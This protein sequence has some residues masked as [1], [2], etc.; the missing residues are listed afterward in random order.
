M[1]TNDFPQYIK[2]TSLWKRTLGQEDPKVEPLR[3]SFL[4]ARKNIVFLLE[5]IHNDFPDLTMHDITHVDSLWRVADTIIGPKYPINPL[6]GY[7]LGIAF[8]IHDAA[9]SYDAI[10]GVDK[11]RET[12]EWKDYHAIKPEGVDDKEFEKQCDF[13]T[14]RAL[15]AKNAEKIL[16]KEFVDSTGGKI[17]IIGHESYRKHLKRIIGKI[18]ASHHWEIGDVKKLR[19]QAT[20]PDDINYQNDWEYNEQKL[21][22]ILRC[23]DAGHFDSG[24][25]PD[26]FYFNRSL[27]INDV[28]RKYWAAQNR[29][30]IVRE[31]KEDKTKLLISSDNPFPKDSFDAW[32]VAYEAVVQFDE[33]LK[34]S[35]ELLRLL[36][37]EGKKGLEFPHNGVVGAESKRLLS[38]YIK[39]EGWEPCSFGV[40]TSNVKGL[41]EKLG[42]SQLYGNNNRLLV[43]LRELIQNARDAMYAR[44]NLDDRYKIDDN[45][46]IIRIQEV[47]DKIWFEVE[48]NGIG[49]SLNCIKHHLL[50][51]GN[52]YW[53]SS[54]C[55][56][57]N[58]GL[59]SS[60]FFSVGEHGIGFYS[61]FMVAKSV[62]V[63]TRRHCDGKEAWKVEFPKGLTMSPILSKTILNT[64]VSTIVRFELRNNEDV[65]IKCPYLQRKTHYYE[66]YRSLLKALSIATIGL[67]ASVQ[68]EVDDK[69]SMIHTNVLSPTFNKHDWLS[70]L[71]MDSPKNLMDLASKFEELIDETGKLRGMIVPPEWVDKLEYSWHDYGGEI[72]FAETIGGL[73]ANTDLNSVFDKEPHFI[74]GYL[75]GKTGN[76]SRNKVILDNSLINCLRIWA[77]K[78]YRMFYNTKIASNKY[79]LETRQIIEKYSK[80]ISFCQLSDSI[81]HEN[82]KYLYS[83]Y[84]E[85]PEIYNKP[86]GALSSLSVIH[87]EL[88]WGVFHDSGLMCDYEESELR[89][90][91]KVIE[92]DNNSATSIEKIIE[93][94]V[95]NSRLRNLFKICFRPE[96]N[97]EQ[98]IEK[99]TLMLSL[100]PFRDG[101]KR[102]LSIWL[103]FLLY[104]NLHKMID[105]K[106]VDYS[107]LIPSYPHY[108]IGHL[109]KP[110]LSS[111]YLDEIANHGT[112]G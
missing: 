41:I 67:D 26:R 43:V 58:P 85:K 55:R 98:I 28:S 63:L 60:F 46:V 37:H 96:S 34:K 33:E 59:H 27:A 49:M 90:I 106:N 91:E 79:S 6:E 94:H 101:N 107:E 72:P 54:L 86:L 18:A 31:Y 14:I 64:N 36:P 83:N 52:S 73:L 10:G 35:N 77:Q 81:A 5:K 62:E 102:T 7:I 23:A 74:A 75:D 21:A 87:R 57:E 99:Y 68:F 112:V 97:Y 105:W 66:K 84:R 25:A 22:C 32:N 51:F 15:H 11:L 53:K 40:H 82:E 65:E 29:L 8:L 70:G 50:D 110:S 9:L 92:N 61:V 69:S 44:S 48:D 88:F 4:E 45:K 103:N 3:K 16:D 109:L 111:N 19:K 93:K 24:R 108:V 13:I 100:H 42:G 38:E 30:G 71:L 47:N 80:L 12:I 2:N 17:Y 89:L 78:K 39:T 56:E 1:D 76:V 104:K 20:P 95:T